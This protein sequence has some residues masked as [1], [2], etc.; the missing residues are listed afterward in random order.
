MSDRSYSQS[1]E[2]AVQLAPATTY[3]GRYVIQRPIGAGGM[4]EVFCARDTRLERTVA[5]KILPRDTANDTGRSRLLNEARAASAL[6]HPNIVALYDICTDR[7]STGGDVDF[8]VMEFVDGRTLTEMIAEAPLSFEQLAALGSQMALALGAAHGAGIVHRDVKP[9][10]IMVTKAQQVKVLDFGIA[11]VTRSDGTTRLTGVGQIIGTVAYMSPEQTR[12]EETDFRS[13][14][15]SLGCVLYEAAVGEPPFKAGSVLGLMHEIVTTE[16]EPP[17]VYRPELQPEF[18]RLVMRCLAK[19]RSQRPESAIELATELRSLAFPTRQEGHVR[20]KRASVAVLPLKVRG[21]ASEQYLA[22]SLAEALVHRLSSTGKLLTRPIASVMR[23]AGEEVDWAKAARE[24]NVDLVVEGTVQIA[25]P[26]IRVLVGIHRASDATTMAS[27]KQDG[28]ASD[29]FALQDRLADAVS[30]VFVPR[31]K[32]GTGTQTPPTKHPGAFELYLR[33]VDRQVHVDKF[34]MASAIELLNRAT[35]LDPS[36]A[37]AWGLLAQAYTQMGAH[38]DPDPKWF[39]LGERAIARTLELDPVQCNA[40]CARGVILW[41]PS[42]SFQNRAALRALNAAIKIDPARPTAR[43]QRAAI[44]WHLGFFDAAE[45]DAMELK[46]A[47]PA[48]GTMHQGAIALQRGEFDLS[49]EHYASALELEPNGVLNHLL[50]PIAVLYAGRLE[51]ARVAIGKARQMFPAESFSLGLEAIVAGIEGD[52]RRAEKLADE[53]AH[54]V[55]SLTHTHHTWH[56]CAAAYTLSGRPEKAIHELERCAAMGL[57]SYRLF[58]ADPYLR[59]LRGE[60]RFSELMTNL[61]RE[62][63][64]IRDEFGLEG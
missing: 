48:L 54:S 39:E 6:N 3:L 21:P 34:E 49:A 42:R 9:A 7:T 32:G 30:E 33:A 19:E 29:L 25:G 37:D 44:L 62:H 24:L 43:H 47:N 64:S 22:V 4:G 15:F 13:D 63:D 12:G 53:A 52:A 31:Q 51:E 61:R 16:P 27:L 1:A 20:E 40:L 14:I 38:L 50:S 41:S 17:S 60:P 45:R 26:K 59:G 18:V 11:K 2:T 56:S 8:L 28:D 57:P 46:L 36:F 58:E 23:Y 35:E 5:I 55:H 10:N